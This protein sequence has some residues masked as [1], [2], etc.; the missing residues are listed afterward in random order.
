MGFTNK[1]NLYRDTAGV[2]ILVLTEIHYGGG[3]KTRK[4]S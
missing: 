3:R 4:R 2:E 1:P